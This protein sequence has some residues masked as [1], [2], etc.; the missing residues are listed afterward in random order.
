MRTYIQGGIEPDRSAE[1]YDNLERS[2]AARIYNSNGRCR[3]MI[4]AADTPAARAQVRQLAAMAI[5][6][7]IGY[8]GSHEPVTGVVYEFV[9]GDLRKYTWL[10][11]TMR[12]HFSFTNIPNPWG[13]SND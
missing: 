1:R 9:G 13:T 12:I 4:S 5:M 3:V 6:Q 11:D 10:L 7:G 8:A 2:L